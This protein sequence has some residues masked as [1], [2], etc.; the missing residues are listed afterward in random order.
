M[1]K[2]ET[3]KTALAHLKIMHDNVET[4]MFTPEVGGY[5]KFRRQPRQHRVFKL[6][7]MKSPN[8]FMVD[9]VWICNWEQCFVYYL[10][11]MTQLWRQVLEF[12]EEQ[13]NYYIDHILDWKRLAIV[14]REGCH[15][16]GCCSNRFTYTDTDSLYLALIQVCCQIWR[17]RQE[18]V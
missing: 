12:N 8:N 5:L 6:I 2:P 1:Y 11:T 14:L 18:A 4:Y 15:T 7:T 3:A 9:G 17:I 13:K 10:P 16:N